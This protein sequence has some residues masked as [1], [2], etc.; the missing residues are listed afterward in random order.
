MSALEIIQSETKS[1]MDKSID[2][3]KHE[4][5]RVRTG[6]ATPAVLDG[7]KVDYYGTPTQLSQVASISVPEARQLVIQPWEKP[8]LGAIEKAIQISGL[9]FN[10]QSDGNAIRVNIPALTEDRRKELAKNCKKIAEDGKVAIRNIRRD[11]NDKLKKAEKAKEISQDEQ[12]N[13]LDDIQKITDG[14]IKKVDV[15]L[16][17]KEKEVMED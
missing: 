1:K 3:L 17:E 11:S 13:A 14:Y 6:R 10:P 2:N 5:S 7:I 16:A 12:K 9:G 15:V 4:F 8:L